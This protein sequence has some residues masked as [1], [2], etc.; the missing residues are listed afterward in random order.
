MNQSS[1]RQLSRAEKFSVEKGILRLIKWLGLVWCQDVLIFWQKT[2][3]KIQSF[4]RFWA[5]FELYFWISSITILFLL[6]SWSSIWSL[7]GFDQYSFRN[8]GA[9]CCSCA[10][11]SHSEAAT[12]FELATCRRGRTSC[13]GFRWEYQ[14]SLSVLYEIRGL[15]VCICFVSI[16]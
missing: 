3:S 13:V 9:N 8:I 1:C 15:N 11:R 14:V 2:T 12:S 4:N 7:L 6:Q 16:N 10:R 5:R